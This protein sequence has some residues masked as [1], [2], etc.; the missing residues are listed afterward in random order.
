MQT[1]H[2]KQNVLDSISILNLTMVQQ[3]LKLNPVQ[4]IIVS[5]TRSIF[6]QTLK[7]FSVFLQTTSFYSK[8]LCAKVIRFKFL[9]THLY[10]LIITGT[11]TNSRGKTT[12]SFWVLVQPTLWKPKNI[13]KLLRYVKNTNRPRQ[14]KCF[15]CI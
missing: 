2:G 6:N 14:T 3:I 12:Y 10:E 15:R 5:V 11:C 9:N 8:I 4:T 13:I 1:G 7:S